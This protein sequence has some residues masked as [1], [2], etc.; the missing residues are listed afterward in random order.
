[1]KEVKNHNATQRGRAP[2]AGNV[3]SVVVW[4]W[5]GAIVVEEEGSLDAEVKVARRIEWEVRADVVVSA[6]SQ[7]TRVSLAR[8]KGLDW[9]R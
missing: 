9:T 3:L 8:S 2:W 1:M 4:I 7:L 5:V 6:M